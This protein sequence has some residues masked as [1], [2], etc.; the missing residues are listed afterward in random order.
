MA[1]TPLLRSLRQL[2]RDAHRSRATGLPIDEI[3]E[4]TARRPASLVDRRRFLAGA[5]AGAAA[6]ALPARARAAR[7]QPTV[8]IVGGGIAGLTCALTLRD[9][10]FAS[11]VYEASARIGGRMFSNTNYFAANQVSE[12]C[13]ELI[14]TGHTTIRHLAARFGLPLDDLHAAEP[15]GSTE[16]YLFDGH[17]YPKAQADADF[18]DLADILQADLDAAPFPTTFDAFTPE[19]F[20]LDHLS[21]RDWIDSRVAGGV[22]SPLGQLLDTAYNIEYGADTTTQS[23]LNLLYLLGFQPTTTQLDVFGESDERF[24]IRGGNQRLPEAI[25]AHLGD[26]VVPGHKLVRLDTTPGG[27]Y[28]ATFE[29]GHT[30]IDVVSDF[31]VLAIPFAVL[32]DVDTRNAGFEPRKRRAIANLGRG[33]NGKLNL[34]FQRR[35]W[36]GTGPWPGK[37]NGSTYSDTGYQA[38]WEVSRAQPGTPGIIVLYSGGSVTDAMRSTTPFALASDPRVA[39]DVQRGL[40]Q[41]DPVFPDLSW[42]GRAA[43]SLPHKSP[44]FGASYSYW[45]VGQYTDFGGF[46]GAPQGGVLFCGEHTSQDFQGF[47]EGGASTGRQTAK[48]L[49]ALLR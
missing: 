39:H 43:E 48:D 38:S 26:A 36:L 28:R 1:R 16:T 10:G 33:H 46:E 45:R 34:Q 49:I 27:R 13:G 41:L 7:N 12:W 18:L 4:H 29:R 19:A 37:A 35:G 11:T 22:D 15:R 47:M 25:A 21:V 3:R 24:H 2:A 5:A 40:A 23:S 42:N 31:V 6:L 14:D 30:T 32:D 17:Y 44:F 9:H 20:T 8:T